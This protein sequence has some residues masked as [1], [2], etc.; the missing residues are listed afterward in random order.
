MLNILV[1]TTLF[2]A[3][4]PDEKE[5]DHCSAATHNVSVHRDGSSEKDVE[6]ISGLPEPISNEA[7]REV[8][9]VID[10]PPTTRSA[11]NPVARS[12]KP[13]GLFGRFSILVEAV[14]PQTDYSR[15]TKWF[16]TF[17]VA[18]A[19]AGA[20]LGSAILYRKQGPVLDGA[21]FD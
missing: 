7:F 10:T 19:A 14:E 17:V 9:A 4:I 15:R 11:D 20:P 16:I 3:R 13:R 18:V 21:T 5:E 12:A 1:Y 8:P 2:M 6:Q